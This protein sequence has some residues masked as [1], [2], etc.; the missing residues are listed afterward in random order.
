[1]LVKTLHQPAL[2]HCQVGGMIFGLQERVPVKLVPITSDWTATSV[3]NGQ[4][5]T[6]DEKTPAYAVA[7]VNRSDKIELDITH[8]VAAWLKGEKIN[9]GFLLETEFPEEQTKFSAKSSAGAKAELVI[10]YTAP[11]VKK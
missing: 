10:Y 4:V 5:L 7:D 9:R 3:Q 11:E 1:M 2:R 6:V 8:L